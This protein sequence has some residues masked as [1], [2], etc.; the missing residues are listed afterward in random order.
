[1]FVRNVI[2]VARELYRNR[3]VAERPFAKKE[4]LIHHSPQIAEVLDKDGVF[5]IPGYYSAEKCSAIVSAI[6]QLW[7][8]LNENEVRTLVE[9]CLD[10]KKFGRG[11][12]QE[13]KYKLWMDR[14]FSDHRII[15][16]EK[17]NPLIQDFFSDEKSL[18]IGRHHLGTI[19]L[20]QFTMANKVVFKDANLGS[21]GGWHRDNCYTKGFKCML[22]LTDVSTDDGPFQYIPGSHHLFYHLFVTN[23]PGQYQ[24]SNEEAEKL[25]SRNKKGKAEITG[26][27]GTLVLFDTNIIHRGKPI[28][29]GHSRYALTNY[30]HYK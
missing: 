18:N 11:V 13:G 9:A 4:T 29:P 25:A 20:N 12:E 28:S 15:G 8:G 22:Y 6:D 16:A 14:H 17:I 24:F 30:Y 7:E 26:K 23:N 2:E 21:G 10:K 19:L 3:V 1:M 5:V 27:A